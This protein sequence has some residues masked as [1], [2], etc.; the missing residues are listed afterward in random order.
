MDD[1][2]SIGLTVRGAYGEGSNEDC[3]LFQISNEV[4]YG[5]TES[6]IIEKVINF[7]TKVEKKERE[8][9]FSLY[10]CNKIKFVD[11]CLRAYGILANCKR[12]EYSEFVNLATKVKLGL[13]LNILKADYPNEI[14]DVM[15][16]ARKATLVLLPN[17]M[18][19]NED[20]RRAEFV[21]KAFIRIGVHP[22]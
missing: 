7:I 4:T 11:S 8:E 1:A 12:I 21:H 19:V 9:R 2:N 6:Q 17:L 15:V 16:S 3:F 5:V 14:D 22:A 20:E 18:C 13:S 10:S